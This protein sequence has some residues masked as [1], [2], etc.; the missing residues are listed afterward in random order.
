M[1]GQHVTIASLFAEYALYGATVGMIRAHAASIAV[2]HAAH[3][4][5]DHDPL[6]DQVAAE[7]VAELDDH[8]ADFQQQIPA[9]QAAYADEVRRNGGI[10]A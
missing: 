9:R 8:A 2:T 3:L 10:G 1:S 4:E 5:G 6:P 7:L